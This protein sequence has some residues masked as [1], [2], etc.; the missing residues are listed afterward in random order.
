M[1]Q[2]T[3]SST[4]WT[5]AVSLSSL[6]IL[7]DEILLTIL[8][9]LAVDARCSIARYVYLFAFYLSVYPLIIELCK[10]FQPLSFLSYVLKKII[11]VNTLIIIIHGN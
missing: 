11:I 3:S 7:P 6:E 8:C 9:F 1:G 5:Q 10:T 4:L 2:S